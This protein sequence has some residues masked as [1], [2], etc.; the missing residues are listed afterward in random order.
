VLRRRFLTALLVVGIIATGCSDDG[1]ET[2]T[3]PPEAGPGLATPFFTTEH[4]GAAG[5]FD[6]VTLHIPI[7]GLAT[8]SVL[9]VEVTGLGQ[10]LTT[11]DSVDPGTGE[12]DITV[13]FAPGGD[14]WPGGETPFTV[15]V[16]V[17]PP[18]GGTI[19][20]SGEATLT[21]D[22]AAVAGVLVGPN[23]AYRVR[24]PDTW[25]VALDT[26]FPES[27]V[28]NT[29]SGL[30]AYRAR[31]E[32]LVFLSQLVP[33][34]TP[35]IGVSVVTEG[36][37]LTAPDL[38]TWVQLQL[39]G[40]AA[41]GGTIVET[42]TVEM[43]HGPG[44]VAT[45]QIDGGALSILATRSGPRLYLVELVAAP[46]T[47]DEVLD[48][49]T[50]VVNSIEFF[51]DR[52]PQPGP[53]ADV[54]TLDFSVSADEVPGLDIGFGVPASWGPD[55]FLEFDDG[56]VGIAIASTSGDDALVVIAEYLG[57]E[58]LTPE[59]FAAFYLDDVATGEEQSRTASSVAGFDT[60]LVVW[61]RDGRTRHDHFVVAGSWAVRIQVDVPAGADRTALVDGIAD[62]IAIGDP[63]AEG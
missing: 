1:G 57:G 46:G 4:G 27:V 6:L 52:E 60:L 53:M 33:T 49:A 30:P 2:T 7:T 13:P 42:S 58:P 59:A 54:R 11:S 45:G 23:G 31:L 25:E 55:E 21:V 34:G 24:Y 29:E 9:D 38:G 10:T 50:A 28:S 14:G 48:E 5:P 26:G 43:S 16:A 51:P 44:V 8:G 22:L 32:T 56:R 47:P 62:G 63:G 19:A 35:G 37:V 20:L 41:R 15:A 61:T 40:F 3:A 12:I 36:A 18:E 39:E 17:T